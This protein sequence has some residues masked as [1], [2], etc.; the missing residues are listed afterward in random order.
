MTMAVLLLVA[1]PA[2][3]ADDPP[4]ARFRVLVPDGAFVFVAKEKMTSTGDERLFESPPLEAG[5]KYSYEISVI[6][7]GR[8]ATC[9]VRF[10]AGSTVEVD[11]RPEFQKVTSAPPRPLKPIRPEWLPGR[12]WRA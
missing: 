9:E 7:E 11:F 6:H 4:C 3:T 8:E 10:E 12:V 2:H 1:V 5:R